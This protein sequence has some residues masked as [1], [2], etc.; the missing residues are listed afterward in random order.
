MGYDAFG[1]PAEQYAIQTGQHPERTTEINTER[2]RQQLDNIGFG[3]D[4]SREFKTTDPSYY[5][6][7]QW[8]F[9]QL[10]DAWYDHDKGNS[11]HIDGLI[12]HFEAHGTEGLNA[13]QTEELSFSAEEW[14]VMNDANKAN[15]LLNYRL[16]YR[17]ESNVLVSYLRNRFGK[18]RSERWPK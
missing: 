12:A 13:A 5:K 3:L 6:W 2:Y 16:A 7:T 14:V 10:F 17:S 1:L 9:I 8:I 15:T 18:R 11:R 4:W